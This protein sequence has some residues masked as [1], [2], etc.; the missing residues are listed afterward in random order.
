[1]SWSVERFESVNMRT[2][3][4]R[5]VVQSVLVWVRRGEEIRRITLELKREASLAGRTLDPREE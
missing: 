1:M 3:P 5:D 2:A 4:Y